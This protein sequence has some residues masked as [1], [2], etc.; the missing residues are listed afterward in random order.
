LPSKS[1]LPLSPLNLL[2][3]KNPLLKVKSPLKVKKRKMKSL[4]LSQRLS[5]NLKKKKNQSKA[6]LPSNTTSAHTLFL[7]TKRPK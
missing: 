7:P 6:S 5:K 3:K 1:Q 2:K 4:H